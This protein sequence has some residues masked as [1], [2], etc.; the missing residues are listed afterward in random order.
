MTPHTE[1]AASTA[2]QSVE[3]GTWLRSAA[4]A[5]TTVGLT[6]TQVNEW[7]STIVGLLTA[8]YTLLKVI[9]WGLA[10][11]ERSAKKSADAAERAAREQAMAEQS[12]SLHRL[13]ELWERRAMAR[14]RPAPLDDQSH[15][16]GK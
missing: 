6:H 11:V 10:M 7:M 12:Q 3:W 13:Q 5:G 9:E 4:G 8:I 14:S 16:E 1:H 15:H 2:A